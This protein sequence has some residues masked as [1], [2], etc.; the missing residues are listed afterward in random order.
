MP[1]ILPNAPAYL[2]KRVVPRRN[3]RK[4]KAEE[5][6]TPAK[7]VLFSSDEERQTVDKPT[8]VCETVCVYEHESGDVNSVVTVAALKNVT[9]A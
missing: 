7:K 2:S 9:P 6:N 3:T 5:I 8:D 4:R 1:T